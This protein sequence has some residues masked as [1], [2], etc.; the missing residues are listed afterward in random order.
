M[1]P[2]L[3]LGP[4]VM[5]PLPWW[6]RYGVGGP[7]AWDVLKANQAPQPTTSA[8][9]QFQTVLHPQTAATP[10]A[11]TTQPTIDPN[12][13]A[14]T[15]TGADST[16]TLPGPGPGTPPPTLPH[17]PPTDYSAY[18]AALAGAAPKA[19]AETQDDKLMG[20]LSGLAAG[21]QNVPG[22]GKNTGNLLLN[23]GLGSLAGLAGEHASYKKSM[24]AYDDAQQ[25]YKE[26]VASG[27]L[28]IAGQTA[29]ESRANQETDYKNAEL[30]WEY[31]KTLLQQQQPKVL[32]TKNNTIVYSTTNPQGGLEVHTMGT[33]GGGGSPDVPYYDTAAGPLRADVPLSAAY[34]AI[35]ARESTG[36]LY[37][38]EAPNEPKKF[39]LSPELYKQ[40]STQATQLTQADS[41]SR[42]AGA[43]TGKDFST[44]WHQHLYQLIYSAIQQ[45]SGQ[46]GINQLVNLGQ[47]SGKKKTVKGFSTPTQDTTDATVQQ[48]E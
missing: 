17:V 43:L 40:L 48:S 31:N 1:D 6:Q 14:A 11:S 30:Q 7:T 44:T 5:P 37:G 35:D 33:G 15:G 39:L 2:N 3:G 10:P 46:A 29:T 26:K 12:M 9:D 34:A 32:S 47:T 38:Q 13:T 28:A 20:I 24:Q 4:P 16:V 8:Y 25:A 23:L 45:Q 42:G 27:E 19:P 22:G 21:L 41:R 36:M 18:R